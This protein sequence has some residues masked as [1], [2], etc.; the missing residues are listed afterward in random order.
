MRKSLETV[1][2]DR[3]TVLRFLGMGALAAP[4]LGARALLKGDR[5]QV[6]NV[7]SGDVLTADFLNDLVDRVNELS[8]EAL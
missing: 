4:M 2:T 5:Q 3:R 1:E 8:K 6:P 7:K